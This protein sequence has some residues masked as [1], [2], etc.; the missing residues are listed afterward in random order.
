[1]FDMCNEYHKN[2]LLGIVTNSTCSYINTRSTYINI[3]H[4]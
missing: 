4:N 3:I 2:N 1:M